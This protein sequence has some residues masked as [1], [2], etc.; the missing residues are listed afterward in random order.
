MKYVF[1]KIT[2]PP[3]HIQ[4]LPVSNNFSG[5]NISMQEPLQAQ[6]GGKENSTVLS[7][8]KPSRF[9]P[10]GKKYHNRFSTL[11]ILRR[12]QGDIHLPD[13]QIPAGGRRAILLR[14]NKA[15]R[16]SRVDL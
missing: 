15:L 14:Q 1:P 6:S 2:N 4:S 13:D 8:K 9:L 12:D 5:K 11:R 3:V 16:V 7:G 10:E